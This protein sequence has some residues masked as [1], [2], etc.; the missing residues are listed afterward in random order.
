MMMDFKTWLKNEEKRTEI[1]PL[2]KENDF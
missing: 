2:R 1:A